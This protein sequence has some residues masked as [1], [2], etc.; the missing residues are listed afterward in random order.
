MH[1]DLYVHDPGWLQFLLGELASGPYAAVGSR[2]QS[3][4]VRGPWVFLWRFSAFLERKSVGMYPRLR[5]LCAL[6]ATDAFRA[7]GCRFVTS[8]RHQDITFAPVEQ[9]LSA[10]HGVLTLPACILCRYMFHR[11]ATTRI[12]NNTYRKN[13]ARHL[14]KV[15]RYR[16]VPEVA[17]ILRD[18]SLDT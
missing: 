13:P 5:S 17:A 18:D 6:F 15:M 11:S 12:A 4:P 2:H 1:S 7:A 8:V 3:I 10:G 14:R 16:R 9:L